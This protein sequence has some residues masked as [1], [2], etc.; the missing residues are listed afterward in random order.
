V[1]RKG[2]RRRRAVKK[3]VVRIFGHKKVQEVLKFALT[4]AVLYFGISGAL[5]LAF[6]T[7]SYWMGVTSNSMKHE[8]DSWRDYFQENTLQ[9]PLQDG[10]ERGDLL[11][12][13]GVS[14]PADIAI[15]DVIVADVGQPLPLVHRV[16]DMWEEEGEVYFKTKGDA[17]PSSLWFERSIK[18]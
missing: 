7:D 2:K 11:V 1:A 16:F 18:P 3:F 8:D 14:A 15:G 6:R 10:F 5:M 12:L 4:L 13:Q 9:F 17:N